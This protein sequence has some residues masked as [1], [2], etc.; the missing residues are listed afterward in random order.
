M[1]QDE[2]FQLL[3]KVSESD[4]NWIRAELERIKAETLDADQME[5]VNAGLKRVEGST[6]IVTDHA[7]KAA[8]QTHQFGP[9]L[10]A[11]L[12]PLVEI[13]L[14]IKARG[15]RAK[16]EQ[17]RRIGAFLHH[18]KT[19]IFDPR[20]LR[21]FKWLCGALG[22]SRQSGYKYLT[23]YKHFGDQLVDFAGIE[24]DKLHQCCRHNGDVKAFVKNNRQDILAFDLKRVRRLAEPAY[25]P[26]TT[27]KAKSQS[28][29]AAD[30]WEPV[31]NRFRK[32]IKERPDLTVE[33]TFTGLSTEDLAA[34]ERLLLSRDWDEEADAS[35][36]LD[37]SSGR[38]E[39]PLEPSKAASLQERTARKGVVYSSPEEVPDMPEG[40]A[41]VAGTLKKFLRRKGHEY[42]E[43]WWLLAD[44]WRDEKMC[45]YAVTTHLQVWYYQGN[46][47][48]PEIPTLGWFLD[49]R[50]S[51]GI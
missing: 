22:L 16:L 45:H 29:A 3:S 13:G 36:H 37:T 18:V 19:Q 41:E 4:W 25:R 21:F 38:D 28:G 2:Y 33:V 20:E 42:E 30:Q 47:C 35:R 26:R 48:V 43:R 23:L 32:C 34:V 46:P 1:P 24:V 11:L 50:D 6:T 31:G 14:R 7:K 15:A 17:V 9:E 51:L 40:L 27:A 39:T 12:V 10:K 8:Q 44:R 5:Y 49:N